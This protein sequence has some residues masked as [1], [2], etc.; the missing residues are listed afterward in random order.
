MVLEQIDVQNVTLC[1]CEKSDHSFF[2]SQ[3]LTK[4][5]RVI[6]PHISAQSLRADGQIKNNI[7]VLKKDYNWIYT[8][9]ILLSI[10]QTGAVLLGIRNNLC[11]IHVAITPPQRTVF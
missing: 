3:S 6:S 2:S 7:Q 4:R 11:P 8:D 5:C 1:S 10:F 9:G